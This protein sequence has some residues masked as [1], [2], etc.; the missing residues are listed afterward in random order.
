VSKRGR[1]GAQGP[2]PERAR[3]VARQKLAE[4]RAAQRRRTAAIVAAVVAAV[5]LVSAG[6]GIA[7]YNAQTKSPAHTAIPKGATA[8]GIVVGKPDA[9]VTVDVYLDFLCPV[10]KQFEDATGPTLARY[11]AAGTVK[12]DYHP[13]AFLDRL[14]AGTRYSTRAAAA[15]GCAADAGVFPKYLQLLYAHQP[16]EGSPGLT[17]AELVALGRQAGATSSS[18]ADCVEQKRYQDWVAGVTDLASKAGVNAT[19]TVLVNGTR[20]PAPTT[21]AV[22]A[23]VEAAAKK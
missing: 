21:A 13:V 2:G 1:R 7:I 11:V 19:P 5:L 14:S 9:K 4:Q 22:T 20:L 23:A 18:F 12:I 15:A 17:A 16:R 8:A 3:E 6:V 10:C